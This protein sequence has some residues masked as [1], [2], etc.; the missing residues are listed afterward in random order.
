MQMTP[1]LWQKV[2]RNWRTS[3]WKWKRRVK[4]WLKTQHSKNK[5]HGFWS[6]HFMANKWGK[7]M[8]TITDLIFLDS[9]I[10]VDS[11]CSHEIKICL[12]F[13]RKV[14]TNL[15]SVLKSR[16]TTLSTKVC[17]VKDRTFPVVMHGCESWTIK[18]T[19]CWRID[20]SILWCWTR[21]SWVP[22][23]ARKSAL[24]IYWKDWWWSWS[25]NPWPSDAKNWLIGK[26]SVAGKD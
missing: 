8:E 16:D 11:N 17:L 24:N 18:K 21:H 19:E 9:K 7:K 15:D 13:Q 23:T 2:K 26:G 6:H 25:S 22:W 20:A 12:L 1:P 4:S 10:T 14:M 5:V 3:W